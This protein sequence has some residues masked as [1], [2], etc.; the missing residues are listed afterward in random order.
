ME[1]RLFVWCSG[2]R[3]LANVLTC[4]TVTFI[5]L[6]VDGW[7]D[8]RIQYL[9]VGNNNISVVPAGILDA[10]VLRYFRLSNN[11]VPPAFKTAWDSKE[12]FMVTAAENGLLQ[13]YSL[14]PRTAGHVQGII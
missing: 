3:V 11:P 7:K 5:S 1:I 14:L 2:C 6:P 8:C 10:P 12:Q 13:N 4:R 9:D